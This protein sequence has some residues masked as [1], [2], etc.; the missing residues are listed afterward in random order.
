MAV[1]GC[2]FSVCCPTAGLPAFSGP[3]GAGKSTT[4]RSH[5]TRCCALTGATCA[6][7]ESASVSLAIPWRRAST[8]VCCH[9]A[10]ESTPN[11]TARE[12]ILYFGALHGLSRKERETRAAELIELLEMGE[13]AD[14][15]A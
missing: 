12:N 14:R 4:L 6:V 13:F 8:S 7:I 1:R 11:L 15:I 2:Q 3:N 5:S 9:M 10:P